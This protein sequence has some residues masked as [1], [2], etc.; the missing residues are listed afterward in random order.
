MT[1]PKYQYSIFLNGRR[2]EQLVI[3]ADTFEELLEAK[4]NID[5]I[6]AKREQEA[7]EEKKA[8]SQA[9]GATDPTT[10]WLEEKG[11]VKICPIHNQEMKAKE[12]KFGVFYSHWLGRD[13][14][15]KPQY[16]N[17]KAK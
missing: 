13:A 5:V 10:N 17:G 2:D 4:K 1:E 15:G 9:P 12:G 6:I 3:R 8:V 14:Q 7:Q 11:A 16:C